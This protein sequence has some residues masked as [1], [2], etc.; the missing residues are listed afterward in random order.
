[1]SVSLVTNPANPIP[2]EAVGETVKDR[3]EF[4]NN[5]KRKSILKSKS[6][7]NQ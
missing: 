7:Q 3:L 1:M 6:N 2:L 4:R 5:T